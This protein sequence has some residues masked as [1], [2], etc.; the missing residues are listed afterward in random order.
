[1]FSLQEAKN[2]VDRVLGYSKLPG[3]EL[4]IQWTEDDFIRF[5][6]NGITTSGYRITQQVSIT[7]TT[8]GRRSGN[9]VVSELTDE[10]LRNGVQ[11][12]EGL[13]AIS[14]PD[15]ENM[16]ALPAQ[17]YPV[18]HNFDAFTASARGDVMIPHVH[19]VIASA[20][21]KK[22][23]AAGYIQRSSNVVAVG[24]KA[25]LFGYHT[26][27]DSS[28][29]HTMRNAAGTSSGWASQSSVS[30][31]DLNGEAAARISTEKCIRGVNRKTLVPGKYT[32]ILE[33]A[34][35]GDLV[36]W[37]GF[38]FGAR[39]AEQGQ[40]F[41]SK[42]GGGTRL[43]EQMFPEFIT[44]RSD[45][46]DPKLASTPWDQSLLPNE[47]IAWIEK[48]VVKNLVYDRFW[49]SKAKIK[50]TPAAGN[51][52]LDGQENSVDD[53][54]R[55]VERGL[56]ITRLWYIRVVQPQTWQLTG[57]SRDGVFLVEKGKVT[58]PV[59][60]FRWNESPAEVL[61]RTAKLSRPVRVT[62]DETGSQ[63]VPALVTSDFNFASVSDAV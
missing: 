47:K 17:K 39:D 3:C 54:I 62:G 57:L 32:V 33:P 48:G 20:L 58:D 12:A 9:A 7:S 34:A 25:G 21:D 46:F 52:V 35:V 27:T 24:N 1:M 28:L 30:L 42:K 6:N 10:A 41:L 44:L 49:A 14:R 51:L 13:A 61:Q 56:L 63:I 16:P 5:A 22:L 23:T 37:L 40:S 45:P 15:P 8:A 4:N 36:G 60:N 43:G 29:S 59:T 2:I 19:A 50:P 31:K 11:Q 26:Y 55:S 53:L 38:A 18:L